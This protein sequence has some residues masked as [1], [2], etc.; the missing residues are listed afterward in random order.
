MLSEP[1]WTSQESVKC[2]ASLPQHIQRTQRSQSKIFFRYQKCFVFRNLWFTSESETFSLQVMTW[3]SCSALSCLLVATNWKTRT[4]RKMRSS[5]D[6]YIW[7]SS[8]EENMNHVKNVHESYGQLLFRSP[9]KLNHVV[10]ALQTIAGLHG[11]SVALSICD[12]LI[13]QLFK[14]SLKIT[15]SLSSSTGCHGRIVEVHG[16]LETT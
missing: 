16:W 3:F 14:E 12:V 10:L 15:P 2:L 9:Q 13:L 4:W 8:Y 5:Y 6:I 11:Q 7:Y 1:C